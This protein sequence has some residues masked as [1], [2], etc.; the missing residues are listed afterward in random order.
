MTGILQA[1]IAAA[2]GAGPV[3]GSVTADRTSALPNV[4]TCNLFVQTNGA[5][6]VGG[7]G[8]G[9]VNSISGLLDWYLPTT[10]GIGSSYW[11][12]RTNST[13]SVTGDFTAG[14]W[15][16]IT[17][18]KQITIQS[19]NT[20][21]GFFDISASSGGAILATIDYTISASDAI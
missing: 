20:A 3:S 7:S 6:Q 21:T 13:G 19:N 12:R 5:L 4:Q 17:A 15:V 11:V 14:S 9:G 18:S 1:L 10:A 16:N 2:S 8:T